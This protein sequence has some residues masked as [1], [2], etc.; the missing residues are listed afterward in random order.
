MI[1]KLSIIIP[2]YNEE[3]TISSILDKVCNVNL[4]ADIKK[5]II[6]VNDCSKD[7]TLQ[8]LNEYCKTHSDADI[9]VLHHEVN[10]GKGAALHTGIAHATGEYLIIQDADMEYDPREYNDLLKPVIEG[11]ADVVF[12]SR[13]L[14]G[15]PHRIL[16]F[17]H[18]IGNQLLTKLSNI[19]TN[20]NLSDMETCYKLFRTDIIQSLDLKENRFGFEPEVTAKIARVP[21]VRIYEVGISYYGR[22]YE[23]GKKIGWKD[24][25]RAILSIFKYNILNTPAN[26][27]QN[28]KL[29]N[30]GI[31]KSSKYLTIALFICVF[32]YFSYLS[33]FNNSKVRGT[34]M[35]EFV[36][37][38]GGY[39]VY[40]PATF[41]YGYTNLEPL[42]RISKESYYGF[43]FYDGKLCNKYTYGVSL[44]ILPFFLILQFFMIIFNFNANGYG[45]PYHILVNIA[46]AFYLALGVVA[47]Y[48][49]LR[50][51]LKRFS[52]IF[53]I[54]IIVFSTNLY[55]YSAFETMMSHVY[56]FSIFSIF[57]F[58]L[59][60]YLDKGNKFKYLVL[61][62]LTWAIATL[63]RPT[64]IFI[65]F[66]I[67]FLDV[68][69]FAILKERFLHFIKPKKFLVLFLL[70][71]IIFIPQFI[72]WKFESG[73]YIYYSYADE[74]FKYL[75]N[76]KLI[77][78]WFAPLN[79]LFLYNPVY[80]LILASLIYSIFKLKSNRF[81]GIIS[82]I[83]IAYITASWHCFYF[84]GA[85][86][87]RS[88]I[89][90]TAIFALPFG[91]FLQQIFEKRKAFLK[92][93]VSV[94]LIVFTY[95]SINFENHSGR[96]FGGEL[97]DWAYFKNKIDIVPFSPF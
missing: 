74:G 43:V 25:F 92:I 78:T 14:G 40:L 94:L 79:G 21:K 81:I 93:L 89:E 95:Y 3:K 13:F 45:P 24:G 2:A 23:E 62:G 58:S 39:Y 32:G 29:K 20:L 77:E 44:L 22:T 53:S 37:D 80:L 70:A 33:I 82:F 47:L 7:A 18:S 8:V 55:F 42:E 90:F 73:H 65:G 12:G 60:N 16:F 46:A 63:I 76:P 41:I 61:I 28:P 6:V 71:L 85:Y 4:I 27:N 49:F 68:N 51:Y 97:W 69:S 1:T 36:S 10:K 87:Q 67:L 50:F 15:N 91:F 86:G 84:G 66:I 57:L 31:S 48:R 72:Y 83:W 75:T 64:N 9:R 96:C 54:L 19:F 38:K 11:F 17:W 88:Y 52:S 30:P 34:W 56:S 59:K 35:D 26:D 5:E